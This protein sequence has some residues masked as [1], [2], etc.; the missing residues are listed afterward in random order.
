MRPY[1][2]PYGT[3]GTARRAQALQAMFAPYGL[4]GPVAEGHTCHVCLRH[5]AL[6][7][8]D[9]DQGVEYS[10]RFRAPPRTAAATAI[11][12]RYV[13]TWRLAAAN[14][15]L[16]AISA[17][18]NS[19]AWRHSTKRG[20]GRAQIFRHYA[21][22]HAREVAVAIRHFPSGSRRTRHRPR[23]LHAMQHDLALLIGIAHMTLERAG[24]LSDPGGRCPQP[25]GHRG[26][27]PSC[28]VC[29]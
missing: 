25:A 19:G 12:A 2:V 9:S 20:K 6:W 28:G 21:H 5:M 11:A 27:R 3:L 8:R 26:S 1:R 14:W 10:S 15:R 24:D 18:R 4:L 22:A 23:S 29:G 17:H 16:A 7:P 13:H